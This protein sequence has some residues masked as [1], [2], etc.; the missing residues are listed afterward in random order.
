MDKEER[1][2]CLQM[3]ILEQYNVTEHD[4]AY[5]PGKDR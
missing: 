4:E 1:N 2:E 5:T 3:G